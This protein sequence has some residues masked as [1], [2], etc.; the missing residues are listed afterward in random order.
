MI[1]RVSG[2]LG[3]RGALAL[4]ARYLDGAPRLSIVLLTTSMPTP[5]PE[6][7]VTVS[8]VCSSWC[9]DEGEYLLVLELH[10]GAS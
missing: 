5:R 10:V 7:F 6:T 2:S 8:D 9:E 1:A 3:H 4:L